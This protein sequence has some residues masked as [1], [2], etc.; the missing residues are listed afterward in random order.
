MRIWIKIRNISAP[1]FFHISCQ[2]PFI[3][4]PSRYPLEMFLKRFF[5]AVSRQLPATAALALLANAGSAMAQA[6]VP[7]WADEFEGTSLNS[8][9]WA[10]QIGTGTIYGL[11]AG[12]GNNELQ[13]YT[14]RPENISVAGGLLKI[15]ARAEAFSGSN[16]TSARIRSLNLKEFTYGKFEARIK[17]P[18]A[19]GVWPAFWMLPT[20]SP[21]GGWAASGE[22]DIVETVNFADNVHGTIHH[23]AQWP[24][25]TSNGGTTSPPGGADGAFHIYTM[26][27]ERDEIRWLFNGVQ[28]YRVGS[29]TWFS[30]NAPTN[31]RAPF[32]TPFH[33]LLNVAVGGNF[34]G[35]PN[36][37]TG[38]PQ[39]MEVDYVRV[40]QRPPKGPFGGVAPTLPIR[41]EAENYDLGGGGV[42]YRD[43]DGSNT[44]AAYRTEE[45]VDIEA[46]NEGGF[47][48]GW[49]N[50][51]EW[52]EY[53]INVPKAGQ[54]DLRARVASGLAGGG[55]FRVEF[56]GVDQTGPLVAPA[57]GGWQTW[58]TVRKLVTLSAGVQTMRFVN[59]SGSGQGFNLNYIDL[60]VPGDVNNSGTLEIGDLYQ[61]ERGLGPNR[62]VDG[63]GTSGTTTDRRTLI[64]FVRPNEKT[65][66][67]TP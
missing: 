40:S 20:N 4:R 37:S 44:G 53:T 3:F 9:N 29:D 64:T 35:P 10:Y 43:A 19:Q 48:V 38:Y 45:G 6:W 12:W 54:Y 57:S 5:P 52:I 23:G 11:P 42:A 2:A 28:Y 56:N 30:A 21:Y 50:N 31:D 27:W 63:D 24:S 55:G 33:L 15:T 47:N 65:Q 67:L 60:L 58:R 7:T 8:A 1:K 51:A 39:T 41:I 36:G 16:Y 61:Y 32:D 17:V 34:P 49:I 22:M 62:D 13:Y 66:L 26:E 25:N 59:T 46:C 14:S 18:G